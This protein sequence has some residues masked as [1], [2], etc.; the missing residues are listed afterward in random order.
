MTRF[1]KARKKEL[2]IKH[3]QGIMVNYNRNAKAI[4]LSEVNIH[5][6]HN[7]TLT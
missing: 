7:R 3:N 4:I 1:D 2:L 6:E 5:D